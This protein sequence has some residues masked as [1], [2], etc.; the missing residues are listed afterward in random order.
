MRPGTRPSGL[1]W[2]A[3][4]RIVLELF[5]EEKELFPSGEDKFTTTVCTG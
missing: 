5:V 4:L 2:F 1:A 3:P